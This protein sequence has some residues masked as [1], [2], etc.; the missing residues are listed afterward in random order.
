METTSHLHNELRLR[1]FFDVYWLEHFALT[2]YPA[3]TNFAWWTWKVLLRDSTFFR[4]MYGGFPIA[5]RDFT[6]DIRHVLTGQTRE[7]WL[8]EG[9]SYDDLLR[10]ELWV[11]GILSLQLAYPKLYVHD[12]AG[13]QDGFGY[14]RTVQQSPAQFERSVLETDRESWA[15]QAK[16]QGLNPCIYTLL[17]EVL[18]LLPSR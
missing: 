2:F 16:V 5:G 7:E 10:P 3:D 17:Y 18:P 9:G 8:T 1:G 11:I 6:L 14:H 15:R 4:L 13:C 12:S